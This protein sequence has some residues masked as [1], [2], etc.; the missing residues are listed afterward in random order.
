[1]LFELG[2]FVYAKVDAD[3]GYHQAVIE[4]VIDNGRQYFVSWVNPVV[5]V[6]VD[7]VVPWRHMRGFILCLIRHE[8]SNPNLIGGQD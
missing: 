8:R 6:M 2:D 4:M 7:R 5:P 1:M 3:G